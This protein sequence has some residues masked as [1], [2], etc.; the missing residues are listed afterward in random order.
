MINVLTANGIYDPRIRFLGRV[1]GI[2]LLPDGKYAVSGEGSFYTN[3]PGTPV[4]YETRSWYAVIPEPATLGLLAVG[5]LAL[6]R[7]RR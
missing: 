5:A 1:Y 7:R 3:A 2:T 6:L 4:T